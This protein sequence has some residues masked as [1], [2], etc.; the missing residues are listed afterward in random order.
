[1]A[2]NRWTCDQCG[3][4]YEGHQTPLTAKDKDDWPCDTPGCTGTVH[5]WKGSFT[6]TFKMVEPAPLWPDDKADARSFFWTFMAPGACSSCTEPMEP[7][8]TRVAF[9]VNSAIVAYCAHC[10]TAHRLRVSFA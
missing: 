6:Y 2:D 1:M 5:K 8:L 9:A 10:G 4:V 3:A 7:D